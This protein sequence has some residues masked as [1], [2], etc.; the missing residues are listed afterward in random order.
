MQG[1]R[2]WRLKWKCEE[3]KGNARVLK[4]TPSPACCIFDNGLSSPKKT[5]WFLLRTVSWTNCMALS[6]CQL[7]P[8]N[9]G[10]ES[11]ELWNDTGCAVKHEL[12]FWK[13][14]FHSFQGDALCMTLNTWVFRSLELRGRIHQAPVL[15]PG[16]KVQEFSL[17][18]GGEWGVE[19]APRVLF[20]WSMLK[21]GSQHCGRKYGA[22]NHTSHLSLAGC[23][24]SVWNLGL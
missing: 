3:V 16:S 2:R 6:S 7:C 24:G 13:F 9:A 21:M 12:I 19:E 5:C 22:T 20:P 8:G 10:Y 15:A 1:N 18:V 14:L 23:L 17:R 11:L 4:L